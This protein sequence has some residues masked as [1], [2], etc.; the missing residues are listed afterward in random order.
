MEEKL[1]TTIVIK[2]L[3]ENVPARLKFLKSDAAESTQIKN[4]LKAMAIS[5]SHVDFRIHHNGKLLFYWPACKDRKSRVEQ[6]LEQ[7]SMYVGRGSS[8]GIQAEAVI[9]SSE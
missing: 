4:V 2:G 1:A 9:S 3:F 5:Y 8:G 7:E 6:V